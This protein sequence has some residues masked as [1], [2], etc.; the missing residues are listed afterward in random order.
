MADEFEKTDLEKLIL[1]L[2][3]LVIFKY[4]DEKMSPKQKMTYDA[5]GWYVDSFGEA[6]WESNQKLVLILDELAS[7]NRKLHEELNAA[8]EQTEDYKRTMDVVVENIR[9]LNSEREQLLSRLAAL[10]GRLEQADAQTAPSSVSDEWIRAVVDEHNARF[11][12]HDRRLDENNARF[13]EHDRRLDENNERF[14]EHDRRLDENNRRFDLHD[15]RLDENNQRFDVIDKRLDENNERFDVIDKRLD[16]NNGRFDVIDGRLDENNERFDMHDSRFDS[17]DS[18][19]GDIEKREEWTRKRFEEHDEKFYEHI[20]WISRLE[21]PDLSSFDYCFGDD[22]YSGFAHSRLCTEKELMSNE[23]QAYRDKLRY[24]EF[25]KIQNYPVNSRKEWEFEAIAYTLDSF[26]MLAEGKKGVGFAVGLEP[27]S[28]YFASR[29]CSVLATDLSAADDKSG[30]WTQTG[31]NAMSSEDSLNCFGICDKDIF[32][33]RAEYRDVDM[34]FIPDDIRG[35]DFCWSSCAIEHIGGLE[36]SKAFLKNVLDVLK[37]GGISVHTTEINLDSDIATIEKGDS[38]I[39]RR[40]DIE[41][42][43]RWMNDNGHKMYVQF[44]RGN[45][46]M[47]RRMCSYRYNVYDY[48]DYMLNC[49][50]DGFDST[51]FIFIIQKGN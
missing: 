3:N 2:N 20:Q 19:I 30:L 18:R 24:T 13:D 47:D 34:N 40:C 21:M 37:P 32:A 27:L 26:G 8:M 38:I 15:K 43:C 22:K 46:R 28:A 42:I 45:D 12:E 1:E 29:G 5:V 41:E 33:K 9:N 6:L 35:F 51:S 31:Q 11:D 36:K 14:D 17:T 4:R 25:A 10:E 50:I 48:T 16:E 7:Q 49:N 23:L 44:R 39:F